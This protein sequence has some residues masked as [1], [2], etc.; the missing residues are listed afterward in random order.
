MKENYKKRIKN[1]ENPSVV[2]PT[3][4]IQHENGKETIF[5]SINYWKMTSNIQIFI[6]G[7][8]N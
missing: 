4:S 1:Q 6:Q 3:E 7:S 8:K 2:L 5:H